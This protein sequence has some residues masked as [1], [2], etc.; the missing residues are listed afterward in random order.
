MGCIADKP[1]HDK[2]EI[3]PPKPRPNLAVKM[4]KPF[5]EKDSIAKSKLLE[6]IKKRDIILFQKTVD[7]YN[8][9]P[10][11]IIGP[12]EQ[13]KTILHKLVEFNFCD[14]MSLMLKDL[15]LESKKEKISPMVNAKDC[16]GNTP[17][18]LC[19]L[20]NSMETLRVLVKDEH[21]D[22]EAKNNANKTALE[23]AMEM[24]SPCVNILTSLSHGSSISTK[25]TLKTAG[26]ESL[27]Y[28]HSLDEV[29]MS[30][31]NSRTSLGDMG[32][33]SFIKD[34]N[35]EYKELKGSFR[36]PQV[37][38]FLE[39]QGAN[40]KDFEFP[41]EACYIEHGIEDTELK[42]K[43]PD[44]AW[45]RPVEFMGAHYES[46]VLF[47]NFALGDVSKSH[48]AGSE[49]Y[50]ALAVMTEFP[51]RL[52]KVFN[53]KKINEQGVYSLSFFV[54]GASIEILV[55]DYFPCSGKNGPLYSRP[56]EH[57]EL[58]F[59]LIEKAF[60]KL[61]GTYK[62]LEILTIMECLEILTGMPM[63]QTK[64]IKTE[65][66]KLWRKL[67]D[68]DK[69]NFMIC[70]R[71]TET[72]NN[73]YKNR[74]FSVVHLYEVD[75][76]RL[77]KLRNHYGHYDWKGDF[78]VNSP[79]WSRGLREQVGYNFQDKS[80]F[81]M[82]IKDFMRVFEVLYVCHYHDNWV[83]KQMN[84][85][86]AATHAVYF[87]VNVEKEM[88]AFISIHQKLPQFCHEGP[89]YDISPVEVVMARDL[90]GQ[91]MDNIVFGEKAAFIGRSTIYVQEGMEMKLNPG[92]YVMNVKIAWVDGKKHDFYINVL[93]SFG[94][95]LSQLER[96]LNSEFMEKVFLS[97]G[98]MSQDK[99]GMGND[100][101]FATGWVGSNL[102]LCA[103]NRGKKVWNLEIVFE[104][105]QNL[106][107]AKKFRSDEE[108]V[109]KLVLQPNQKAVAYLKRLG[110]EKVA[111][112][113]RFIQSWDNIKK[114]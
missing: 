98:I 103:F 102:W 59:M 54:S 93:S 37:I 61:Y 111:F 88:E 80:C 50:S 82:T 17:L 53:T 85:S 12:S 60:A 67:M 19:C 70:G 79:V 58:W 90:D 81:F 23:I 63:S 20:L 84:S 7:L 92:R 16:D 11:D 28:V 39:V 38:G 76:C 46:A 96:R 95:K 62:E 41:H 1:I 15:S 107:I 51:Q 9:K 5:L 24:E 94:V 57:K 44:L 101:D 100:C 105:L 2:N 3:P 14:G 99:Y 69:K 64:L 6:A 83:R 27:G 36:Y 31:P 114:D 42:R 8:F 18:L 56:G 55:D 86:C 13:N 109:I 78:S 32:K 10:N 40:F 25:H 4:T 34:N 35:A 73:R 72:V 52:S 113:W 108:R 43:Y 66:D 110:V 89:D 48:L 112:K 26:P 68:Y 77:L 87:E 49:F 22:T 29:P 30:G 47:D 21:T 104:T 106:K 71:E 75:G 65:E 91:N 45:K 97:A 74:V 33:P